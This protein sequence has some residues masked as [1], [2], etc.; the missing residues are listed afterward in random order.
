MNA[1][2]SC[3]ATFELPRTLTIT[4]SGTGSGTVG[5][6]GTYANNTTAQA[7]A[8]AD[9]GSLFT[10]WSG[11]CSGTTS[12]FSI[13]MNA[14]KTCNAKFD[15]AHVLTI[16]PIG[17][18]GGTVIGAGTYA[19]GSTAQATAT[20]NAVSVF[21]GWGGDC[22]TGTANPVDV[23]MDANKTC[24]ASFRLPT[25]T[26]SLIGNG[27]GTVSSADNNINCPAGD[28]SHV[29]ATGA[30]IT[31]TATPDSDF[32]FKGWRG[33]GI[34]CPGTAPCTVTMDSYK[35][36]VVSFQK[37]FSWLSFLPLITRKQP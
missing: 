30:S 34:N 1:D 21:T 19:I 11:N 23:L 7:T 8:V 33:T 35:D 4:K 28:C 10:G 17:D 9:S 29:Y 6:A 37:E 24:T 22:G 2:K 32:I 15:T 18:G 14:N 5:G 16:T 27:T 3:T 36:I 20:A 26:V 12:P 25:L 31:L 13:L